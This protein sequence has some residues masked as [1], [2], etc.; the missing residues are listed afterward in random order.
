VEK[1]A[2]RVRADGAVIVLQ[3]HEDHLHRISVILFAFT[4]FPEGWRLTEPVGD[5]FSNALSDST[6]VKEARSVTGD[7]E[8]HRLSG[9]KNFL[10]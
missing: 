10:P 6:L 4:P 7:P 3:P 8:H 9:R 2:G 1:G 5:C